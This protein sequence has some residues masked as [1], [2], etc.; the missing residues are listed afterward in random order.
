MMDA[1]K[2]YK[3]TCLCFLLALSIIIVL[4]SCDGILTSPSPGVGVSDERIL[5]IKRDYTVSSVCSIKPDG[6]DLRTIASHD[7]AGEYVPQGYGN[8]QWSPDKSHILINGGPRESR[9]VFPLW[10]MDNQG[11]LLYRITWYGTS[12]HWSAD[13]N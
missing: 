8:A 12:E 3:I 13:G 6:T 5:F 7:A 11:N 4:S 2:Y 10:L 9:E 1:M